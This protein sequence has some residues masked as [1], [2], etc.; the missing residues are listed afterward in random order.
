MQD[1]PCADGKLL[2]LHTS[3]TC[4]AR[5]LALSGALD[6]DIYRSQL[7]QG[8]QWLGNNGEEHA[9]QAFSALLPMLKDV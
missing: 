4:L 8:L 1:V 9:A 2:A 3:I 5:A 7:D 6:R